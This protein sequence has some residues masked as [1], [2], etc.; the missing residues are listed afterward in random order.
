MGRAVVVNG[1]ERQISGQSPFLGFK[2]IN[3]NSGLGG[4]VPPA[5]LNQNPLQVLTT[6]KYSFSNQIAAY[7]NAVALSSWHSDVR[8]MLKTLVVSIGTGPWGSGVWWGNS[9]VFF[10]AMWLGHALATNSWNHVV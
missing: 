8:Q 2:S 1:V 9:Q 3:Q 10:I 7:Y 4:D 5:R 6:G